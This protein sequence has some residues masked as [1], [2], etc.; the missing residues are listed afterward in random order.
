MVQLQNETNMVAVVWPRL[1][2][3]IALCLISIEALQV[4]RVVSRFRQSFRLHNKVLSG[5][6]HGAGFKF[7]PVVRGSPEE[8][9]PRIIHIAGFYPNLSVEQVLAPTS[10]PQ[11]EPGTWNYDFPDPDGPQLGT[12]AVPG[13]DVI[14]DCI[15]PVALIALNTDLGIAYSEEVECVVVIDRGDRVFTPDKF[16]LFETPDGSLSIEW[17][18]KHDPAYNIIGRVELTMMPWAKSMTPKATGFLEEDD[19]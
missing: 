15:D 2:I 6:K 10:P 14:T 1:L 8:H 12:V 13:S 16:F 5:G 11:P 17:M 18:K 9:L 19:G 3:F 4:G 7:L